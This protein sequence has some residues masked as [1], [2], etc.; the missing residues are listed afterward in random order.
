MYS[1]GG[2]NQR[3][4][5][6]VISYLKGLP[7]YAPGNKNVRYSFGAPKGKTAIV[8]AG[9]ARVGVAADDGRIEGALQQYLRQQRLGVDVGA[10]AEQHGSR[11]GEDESCNEAG[12]RYP[13]RIIV[14]LRSQ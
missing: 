8:I 7:I 12:H 2:R 1:V 5:L 13:F 6:A 9:S 14:S 4:T 3:I 11:E 10:L